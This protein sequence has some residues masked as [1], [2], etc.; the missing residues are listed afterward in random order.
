[1]LN[2]ATTRAALGLLLLC[3]GPAQAMG[4]ELGFKAGRDWDLVGEVGAKYKAPAGLTAKVLREDYLLSGGTLVLGS[5]EDAVL[6]VLRSYQSRTLSSKAKDRKSYL[7]RYRLTVLVLRDDDAQW[8]DKEV[9]QQQVR[10]LA[11]AFLEWKKPRGVFS[12]NKARTSKIGRYQGVQSEITGSVTARD[13]DGL[14][15]ALPYRAHSWAVDLPGKD[16]LFLLDGPDTE[17]FKRAAKDAKSVWSSVKLLTTSELVKQLEQAGLAARSGNFPGLG[18]DWTAAE[19]T[20]SA[21]LRVVGPS[22]WPALE[23]LPKKVRADLL[24][25]GQWLLRNPVAAVAGEASAIQLGV[26]ALTGRAL[27]GLNDPGLGPE[28][29]AALDR[30]VA[31]LLEA[32]A[33]AAARFPGLI[34]QEDGNAT[35]YAHSIA[36]LFLLDCFGNPGFV[37]RQEELRAPLQSALDLIL[38]AQGNN[39]SWRYTLRGSEVKGRDTSISGWALLALLRARELGFTLPDRALAAGRDGLLALAGAE[40]GRFGYGD[41][42]GGGAGGGPAR[43][44][45]IYDRFPSQLSESLTG[46]GLYATLL[47][48]SHLTP[49]G[50]PSNTQWKALQLLMRLQ[51]RLEAGAYDLYY[52]HY[53]SCALSLFGGKELKVWREQLVSVLQERHLRS[54]DAAVEGSYADK[55]VWSS[56][57]GPAYAT[58]MAVL[59]LLS[60]YSARQQEILAD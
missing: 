16:L 34:G 53:G 26:T 45:A 39:G 7:G 58:S 9:R 24:R 23:K 51:P 37:A 27:L 60:A 22:T 30:V 8:P 33:S 28:R 11:T 55:S 41:G 36:T 52:W 3:A 42:G 21:P 46:I 10:G 19:R 48:D 17:A 12:E 1:M 6:Q 32:Q 50:R 4:Q 54:A 40:F 14:E 18:A 44:A 35:L 29:Q 56:E 57:G 25:A 15:I 38:A 5:A 59:A 43:T 31:F 2:L 13:E 20:W 47:V 49:E